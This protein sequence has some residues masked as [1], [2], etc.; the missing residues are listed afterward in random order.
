MCE[1]TGLRLVCMC[2]RVWVFL[3][4][5]VCGVP[6]MCVRVPGCSRVRRA[7]RIWVP[8]W[9]SEGLGATRVPV[10]G[11]SGNVCLGVCAPCVRVP[12]PM[13]PRGLLAQPP[14]PW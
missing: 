9:V 13:S 10:G 14:S 8:T 12:V 11:L 7:V 4:V 1:R 3:G 2:V 5:P 6:C